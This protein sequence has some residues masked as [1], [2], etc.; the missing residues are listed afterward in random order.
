M[1]CASIASIVL[2]VHCS[3]GSAALTSEAVLA[4][5]GVNAAA[6][7]RSA[8]CQDSHLLFHVQAPFCSVEVTDRGHRQERWGEARS[9][10]A[11]S[12]VRLSRAG[13]CRAQSQQSAGSQFSKFCFLPNPMFLAVGQ[14]LSESAGSPVRISFTPTLMPMS[15]GMQ[16]TIYVKLANGASAD[17]LR[18]HLQVCSYRE[19]FAMHATRGRPVLLTIDM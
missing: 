8:I 2:N 15:R 3:G 10:H 13:G 9:G 1:P 5:P 11:S 18:S 12:S 14:G 16:S 19:C 17:D 6:T 4:L 7:R